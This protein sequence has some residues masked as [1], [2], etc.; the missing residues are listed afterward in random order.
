MNWKGFRRKRW[1]NKRGICLQ[2]L[3]STTKTLSDDSRCRY[4]E[5]IRVPPECKSR[6]LT[7]RK[8]ARFQPPLATTKLICVE[9]YPL[10]LSIKNIHWDYKLC[11]LWT[12]LRDPTPQRARARGCMSGRSAGG[13]GSP[14]LAVN[15]ETQGACR[16]FSMALTVLI[17]YRSNLI[18]V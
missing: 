7:L 3:K 2:V 5:S 1:R 6:T 8:P 14:T 16:Y 17:F 18:A 10:Q 13:K 9:Y 11:A 12:G 15:E 4:R